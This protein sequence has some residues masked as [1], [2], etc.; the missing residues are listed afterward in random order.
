M[1]ILEVEQNT[2]VLEVLISV[3][4]RTPKVVAEVIDERC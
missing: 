1:A 4:V 3:E 2:T